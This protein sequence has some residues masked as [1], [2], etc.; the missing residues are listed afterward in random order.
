MRTKH[1]LIVAN[2]TAAGEHLKRIVQARVAAGSCRFTL[3]VPGY[4]PEGLTWTEGQAQAAAQQQLDEALPALR[5]LGAQIEG[6]VGDRR[7]LLSIEDIIRHDDVDEIV[8]STWPAGVSRWL[9]QDL[10][11]RIRRTFDIPL[12]HVVDESAPTAA[13]G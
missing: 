7:P 10:P 6:V 13:H 9:G 4:H 12:T 2:Q 5:S 11:H 8:V 1:I 3:V